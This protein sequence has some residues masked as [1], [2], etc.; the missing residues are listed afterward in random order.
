MDVKY[1]KNMFCLCFCV[2]I[3]T[4][5]YSYVTYYSANLSKAFYNLWPNIEPTAGT[6]PLNKLTHKEQITT[7]T[8]T[9]A[10]EQHMA[11]TR[12]FLGEDKAIQEDASMS[13]QDST[14]E[15][16]VKSGRKPSVIPASPPITDTMSINKTFETL[17]HEHE[18]QEY[19][20]LK[21]TINIH[22]LNSFIKPKNENCE[23]R[24]PSCIIIGVYKGG[25][26][27]I[28]D[29]LKLHP[30]VEIYPANMQKMSYEMPYLSV[31][32]FINWET[33]G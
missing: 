23:R 17:A 13:E 15:N 8:S 18:K 5:I 6:T 14:Y 25:T 26:N 19:R 11:L 10:S 27:E 16:K 12:S 1:Y 24:L 21:R 29:F 4:V 9:H 22:H 28:V 2:L 33:N 32:F 20:I 31:P 3:S 7:E 30:H